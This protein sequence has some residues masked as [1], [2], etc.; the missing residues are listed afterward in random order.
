MNR[1]RRLA[2]I[3]A[4]LAGALLAVAAVAPAALAD[5]FPP[6]P[7]GWDKHPPLPPPGAGIHVVVVGGLPGWQIALIAIGAALL[8]ASAAAGIIAKRGGS[9][10]W[11]PRAKMSASAPPAGPPG[12]SR[13]TGP[14]P[15]RKLKAA[16]KSS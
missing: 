3:P 10:V 7:P 1:I 4:G 13:A 12:T 14:S 8:A 11:R 5:P 2:A 9:P 6:R 15:G 16:V